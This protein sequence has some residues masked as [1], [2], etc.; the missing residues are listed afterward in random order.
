MSVYIMVGTGVAPLG[1]ILAGAVASWYGTPISILMG[2]IITTLT[3]IW[4]ARRL[5]IRPQASMLGRVR[6]AAR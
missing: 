5:Q 1:A 2:G 6:N 3:A 4:L